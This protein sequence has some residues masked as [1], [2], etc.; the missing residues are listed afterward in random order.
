MSDIGAYQIHITL[1]LAKRVTLAQV[2]NVYEMYLNPTNY[3]ML[4]DIEC[5]VF[6]LNIGDRWLSQWCEQLD[7]CRYIIDWE[8]SGTK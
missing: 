4:S 6:M 2:I 8:M 3:P 1:W 7:L 5:L